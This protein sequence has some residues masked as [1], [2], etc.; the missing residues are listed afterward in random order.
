MF[1]KIKKMFR[2][3][4]NTLLQ[5]GFLVAN[6]S[7]LLASMFLMAFPCVVFALS[8]MCV[9]ALA[10]GQ[11]PYITSFMEWLK[12]VGISIISWYLGSGLWNIYLCEK[13]ERSISQ[14]LDQK[15]TEDVPLE[16]V[17]LFE[18]WMME[19]SIQNPTLSLEDALNQYISTFNLS[20]RRDIDEPERIALARTKIKVL[21]NSVFGDPKNMTDGQVQN[22]LEGL[23]A[24]LT[25]YEMLDP[26]GK[27][28]YKQREY[29]SRGDNH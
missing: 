22:Y 11:S 19:K 7:L 13:G 24:L 3:I 17:P 6:M 15:E 10:M 29:Q 4:N 2:K 5:A 18:I 20:V 1:R 27:S 28:V 12:L 8:L 23:K 16:D 26:E 9:I 14:I 25:M 21:E